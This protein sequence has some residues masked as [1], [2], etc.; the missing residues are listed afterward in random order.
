MVAAAYR[1][2]EI[3]FAVALV[4]LLMTTTA[5][6]LF[7]RLEARWQLPASP[8]SDLDAAGQAADISNRELNLVTYYSQTLG[9]PRTAQTPGST[10]RVPPVGVNPWG[11]QPRLRRG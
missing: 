11:P 9:A 8:A 3:S 4:Y 6:L 10:A 7:K 1:A 2:F 5:S